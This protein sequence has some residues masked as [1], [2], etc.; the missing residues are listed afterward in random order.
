M[1]SQEDIRRELLRRTQ[2]QAEEEVKQLAEQEGT[3]F[4]VEQGKP[5][6]QAK[7]RVASKEVP[8]GNEQQQTFSERFV[9]VTSEGTVTTIQRGLTGNRRPTVFS[10]TTFRPSGEKRFTQS[11]SR[12]PDRPVSVQSLVTFSR[13]ATPSAKRVETFDRQGNVV[14]VARGGGRSLKQPRRGPI[15]ANRL[16][17][18]R[19][20]LGDRPTPRTTII[21]GRPS[22]PIP[23]DRRRPPRRQLGEPTR[24]TSTFTLGTGIGQFDKPSKTVNQITLSFTPPPPKKTA[25]TEKP[26]T[27]TT[28]QFAELKQTTSSKGALQDALGIESTRTVQRTTKKQED[29]AGLGLNEILGNL[30]L[31]GR[32]L[33]TGSAQRQQGITP[34]TR[35][36]SFFP[37]EQQLTRIRQNLSSEPQQSFQLS[38][39]LPT[40]QQLTRI[41]QNLSSEP[42]RNFTP[43]PR[44]DKELQTKAPLEDRVAIT[45][46][47]IARKIADLLPSTAGVQKRRAEDRQKGLPKPII[48]AGVGS[49]QLIPSITQ[50]GAIAELAGAEVTESARQDILEIGRRPI[51]SSAVLG[52]TIVAGGALKAG[53]TVAKTSKLAQKTGKVFQALGPKTQALIKSTPELI[54]VGVAG[55]ITGLELRQETKKETLDLTIE[56]RRK[57]RAP[58]QSTIILGTAGFLIG[59]GLVSAGTSVKS[60]L[61]RTTLKSTEIAKTGQGTV[62]KQTSQ[63][64]VLVQ[65]KIFGVK[66]GRASF[67]VTSETTTIVAPSGQTA[68]SST[69]TVQTFTGPKVFTSAGRGKFSSDEG[70]AIVRVLDPKGRAISQEVQ[71]SQITPL[72]EGAT[73]TRTPFFTDIRIASTTQPDFSPIVDV[74]K[75]VTR[76]VK[77]A[78]DFQRLAVSGVATTGKT[79]TSISG[80][81][82]QT[83]TGKVVGKSIRKSLGI[84]EPTAR[85]IRL[86]KRGAVGIG[87]LTPE[88]DLTGTGVIGRLGRETDLTGI[89]SIADLSKPFKGVSVEQSL[90]G[91]PSGTSIVQSIFSRSPSRLG[92]IFLPAKQSTSGLRLGIDTSSGTKGETR[93]RS[94][95]DIDIGTKTGGKPTVRVET[96]PQAV[97]TPKPILDIPSGTGSGARSKPR[98]KPV[99]ETPTKKV[100]PIIIPKIDV[101]PFVPPI[102]PFFPTPSLGFAPARRITRP[103]RPRR[104]FKFTPS[105]TAVTLGITG[106]QQ[107]GPFLGLELRPIPIGK[108]KK[109]KKKVKK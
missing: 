31:V 22:G 85:S 45:T 21:G 13:T 24:R 103:R 58:Q 89:S 12:S 15:P 54:E 93:P 87:R 106:R 81:I 73:Q 55:T 92:S 6:Q 50:G 91:T 34:Q 74:S 102:V 101:P 28:E 105:L 5:L 53:T 4:I 70:T 76:T 44:A 66:A 41:R 78:T 1:V 94:T 16:R 61:G 109:K 59:E 65:Q 90:L 83:E 84:S 20:Q 100:P 98:P 11:F 17:E 56:E 46:R 77:K 95:F 99:P 19:R 86:G 71:V 35:T 72:R 62:I 57:Q 10:S 29:E 88:T 75:S 82:F 49:G 36:Q 40:E 51:R 30:P 39:F 2:G 67:P 27:K 9:D 37:T 18:P 3:T 14:D 69:A 60:S 64:R 104:Q 33:G 79:G 97:P 7:I 47:P 107:K 52:G 26:E 48:S 8:I 63:S 25:R 43:I 96:V 108:K 68:I 32:F 42:Q 80:N 38:T 23:E